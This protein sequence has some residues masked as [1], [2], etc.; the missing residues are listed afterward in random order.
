MPSIN[1][2]L[3]SATPKRNLSLRSSGR[4]TPIGL[5]PN[6]SF[7]ENRKSFQDNNETPNFKVKHVRDIYKTVT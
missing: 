1:R 5:T 7:H 6:T 4:N 3:E 2:T